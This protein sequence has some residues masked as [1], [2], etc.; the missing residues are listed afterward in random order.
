MA[1]MCNRTDQVK[2]I[3]LNTTANSVETAPT[4]QIAT[5]GIGQ[6][7]RELRTERGL[8]VRKLA[9]LAQ[10]S[11]SLISHIE[12]GKGAPSVKTLYALVAVLEIPLSAMFDGQPAIGEIDARKMGSRNDSENE[13]GHIGS[14]LKTKEQPLTIRSHGPV[15][16]P[17][18]RRVIHLEHGF[19]WECLTPTFDPD[20]EFMEVVIEVGGGRPDLE[21]RTHNGTEYGYVL[22]GKLGIKIAFDNYVL[23]PGDSI[24]FDS[25]LPHSFWNA[26]EEP[27][28]SIWFVRGRNL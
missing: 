7:V 27:T 24:R 4:P 25:T 2:A 16:R 3:S 6:R 23:E 22:K 15:V 18:A 12:L 26:G 13:T 8:S 10:V 14:A 5:S 21:M 20:V 9:Q 28:H 19:R 17:D 11:P 1:K